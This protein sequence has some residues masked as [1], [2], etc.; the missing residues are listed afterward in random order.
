M[1]NINKGTWII[2]TIDFLI[3]ILFSKIDEDKT[4]RKKY[5]VL[6]YIIVVNIEH[7]EKIY[8]LII[9]II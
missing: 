7:W 9:L 8:L 6:K 1:N 4:E 2:N 5:N 3:L